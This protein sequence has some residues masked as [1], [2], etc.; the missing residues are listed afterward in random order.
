MKALSSTTVIHVTDL[1]SA[2]KY[3]T[4]ILGFTIDFIFGDYAGLIHGEVAIHLN[5]PTNTSMKKLP[6]NAHL[7]IDCDEV[8]D[9]YNRI[10]KNGAIISAPIADRVYGVRDFAVDDPDGNTLV[11]GRAID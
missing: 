6:G 8:D 4:D 5:G 9:Y 3:Y 11:F 10:S 1:D 2:L 7:C